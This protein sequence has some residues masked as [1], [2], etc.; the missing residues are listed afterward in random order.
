M[1][2]VYDRVVSWISYSEVI[3]S[4]ESAKQIVKGLLAEQVLNV[5]GAIGDF[6]L[7]F[8]PVYVRK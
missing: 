5:F 4:T 6:F 1:C 3:Y 2:L 7:K 8:I